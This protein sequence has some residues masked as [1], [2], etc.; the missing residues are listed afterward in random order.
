MQSNHEIVVPNEDLPFKMFLF[1]GEKGNYFRDK[2]WHRS[3]EIFMVF[4]GHLK[5]YLNDLE[6]K[7]NP[8]EFVL[9]NSN[10]IHAIDSPEPNKTVVIQIPL[11]TFS[12]YF[13]G[14]QYIRFT[15]ESKKQDV[16]V[17]DLI[18]EMFAAYG[19][20]ETG[21]DMRVKSGY[22]MLLYLLVSVYR[23]L[24]VK[25][26]L[27]KQNRK[28]NKLTPITNY[29][30][31]HY[32][33]ELSL[34][35]LAEVFGYAPAYI[36]RMFQKYAGINYKDYLQGVR[37]EYAFAELNRAEHTVSEVAF[38]HGFPSSRAFSKAFQKKYGMLPSAYLQ[39]KTESSHSSGQI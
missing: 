10:E 27:L 34:E 8:G 18:R 3:I 33:E 23:E 36:S 7:L 2:H 19:K 38:H 25:D 26:E 28:L 6:Q 31:E 39:R 32:R 11:K 22:Y 5:F 30:K 15:H 16:Q 24:D 37:V 4:E 17:V 1:E 12:D 21:Y 13:T 29:M 14:E 9:V 35:A 20:K